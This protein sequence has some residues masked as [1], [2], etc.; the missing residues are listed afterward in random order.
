VKKLYSIRSKIIV[1]QFTTEKQDSFNFTL[2]I[3]EL[4]ISAY[5]RFKYRK[6]NRH[7]SKMHKA[8]DTLIKDWES[9]AWKYNE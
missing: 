9:K 3:V 2:F 6:F 8:L 7:L 5:E 4:I 1:K